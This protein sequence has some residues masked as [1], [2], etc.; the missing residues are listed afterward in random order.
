[1]SATPSHQPPPQAS[2]TAALDLAAMRQNYTLAE[3]CEQQAPAEPAALFDA[4]LQQ[5][6]QAQLHEPNAM[7]L[8]TVGSDLRP[9]ARIVLL[10]GHDARGLVWFTNY[11]SRKGQ[12]LAGNPQAALLFYWGPLQ[13]SVRIEG[14]VEKIADEDSASYFDSRPLAS[15]IGALASPQSQPVASRQALDEAFARIEAELAASGQAPQ[16]PPFWGGY[17]L[18]P[19][20]WEFWQ[21]RSGRLHDRIAYL[22]PAQGD[23]AVA[24]QRQRLAP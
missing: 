4:W 22:R 21:G 11:H 3:L 16:R 17:R 14:V 7:T 13:R 8:A 23:G 19:S 2:Q 1:M 12:E 20:Y 24:W 10:K 9:S 6:V 5:A 18:W 15:R